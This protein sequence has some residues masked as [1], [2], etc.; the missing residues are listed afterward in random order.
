MGQKIAT[1]LL[2]W[3]WPMLL[4]A[5][6]ITACALPL[7]ADLEFDRSL[8]NM[9]SADDPLLPPLH[10]MQR[11]FGGNEVILLVYQDDD[12]MDPQGVGIRRLR[13]LTD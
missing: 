13:Q 2:A 10:K 8:E 3:R 6:A 7:S 9:F 4:L 12:L 5:I 1:K 11:T